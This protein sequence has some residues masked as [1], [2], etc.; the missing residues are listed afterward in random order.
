VS[1]QILSITNI[2][3]IKMIKFLFWLFVVILIGMIV[4]MSILAANWSYW[5]M[6]VNDNTSLSKTTGGSIQIMSAIGTIFIVLLVI[7]MTIAI[8]GFYHSLAYLI[9]AEKLVSVENIKKAHHEY[10]RYQEWD[11][12]NNKYAAPPGY[13]PVLSQQSAPLQS[14][15]SS[16][17]VEVSRS[18]VTDH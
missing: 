4:I 3:A 12:H 2:K 13:S 5:G 15:V 16:R 6:Y 1:N 17:S 18:V 9:E 10:G 7:V 14:Q 11:R 8:V